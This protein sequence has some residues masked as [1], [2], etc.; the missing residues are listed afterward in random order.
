MK[1]LWLREDVSKSTFF[2]DFKE[3]GICKIDV[4]CMLF[5]Q[6]SFSVL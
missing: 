3:S 6:V 1:R 5:V 4:V 2:F